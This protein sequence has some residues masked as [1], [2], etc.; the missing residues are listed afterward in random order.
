L[1]EIGFPDRNIAEDVDFCWRALEAGYDVV[2]T[3]AGVIEH[4]YDDAYSTFVS[5]RRDYGTSEALLSNDHGSTG[6]VPISI[7]ALLGVGFLFAALAGVD[8][9]SWGTAGL[10][11]GLAVSGIVRTFWTDRRT[12]DQISTRHLVDSKGREIFSGIYAVARE[13]G[14]YY[15]LPF[16]V[17]SLLIF[18]SGYTILAVAGGAVALGALLLPAAVSYYINPPQ[19]GRFQYLGWYLSDHLAYQWGTYRGIYKARTI[20]HLNPLGRFS[21]GGPIGATIQSIAKRK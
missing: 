11:G 7:I 17:G 21:L 5:R 13:I 18:G 9:A 10:F 19:I 14:R 6:N 1:E 4:D 20:R 15:S 16:A 8:G 3:A 12:G 2:Y